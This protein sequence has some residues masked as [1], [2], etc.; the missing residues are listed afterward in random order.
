MNARALVW[1]AVGAVILAGCQRSAPPGQASGAADSTGASG[2]RAGDTARAPSSLPLMSQRLLEAATI[3]LPPGAAPDSLPEPTSAGATVL[4]KYCTQCHALP[5]PAMHGAV[6]WPAI[7]RR[8]WVRID[9]MAGAL[10]I[11]TP[12]TAERAQLLA[13]LQANALKVAS[14]L[15]PGP[16]RDQF[17]AT[18]SRCHALADPMSHSPAD[19]PVVVMRMERNMEKMR[20]SG[21][22]H[23]QATEIVAYLQRVSA[24]RAR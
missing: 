16:G 22:T 11:Q 23:D 6:E 15:P 8:M 21:V 18:C 2:S 7:A 9:M 3:A 19:W 1:G 14:Q 13:Y 4:R 10:N 12:S 24:R 5:S 17:E 20:V